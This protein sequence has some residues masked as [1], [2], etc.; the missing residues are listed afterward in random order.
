MNSNFV[1]VGTVVLGIISTGI[2]FYLIFLKLKLL[3][4]RKSLQNDGVLTNRCNIHLVAFIELIFWMFPV[5]LFYGVDD[6]QH[7]RYMNRIN[8]LWLIMLISAIVILQM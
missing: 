5:I 7:R 2:F 4:I 3:S 1:F 6:G 8:M